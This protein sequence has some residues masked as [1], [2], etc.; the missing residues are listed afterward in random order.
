MSLLRQAAVP[1]RR[2]VFVALETKAR[3]CSATLQLPRPIPC[4][5]RTYAKA[6]STANLVPGSQ[7]PITDEAAREEYKKCEEKM[8]TAVDWFR[9]ECGT[10]QARASGRITPAVL[11]PVRVRLPRDDHQYK[12]EEVATVGVRDGNMLMVTVFDEEYLKPVEQAI[13]EAKLPNMVPQRF[14]KRTVS[15]PIPKPTVEARQSLV[16]GAQKQA[17]DTRQQIRKHHQASLKR[18]KY[19]KH[20]I[21]LEEFQKL[22]HRYIGEVDSVINQLKKETGVGK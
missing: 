1:L 2:R 7:Q 17:E 13:Y 15:V 22:A 3:V 6:K 19:A 10:I 11:S 8:K 4:Q 9:K 12:L 5:R 18:G 14:D 16:T 20:S 21:E